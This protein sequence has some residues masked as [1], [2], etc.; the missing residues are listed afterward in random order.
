MYYWDYVLVA[1]SY[2]ERMGK[3]VNPLCRPYSQGDPSPSDGIRSSHGQFYYTRCVDVFVEDENASKA[4]WTVHVSKMNDTG[5]AIFR[6]S[7]DFRN[8]N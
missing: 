2:Q 7:C 5:L 6:P 3:R 1:A 4:A 8:W